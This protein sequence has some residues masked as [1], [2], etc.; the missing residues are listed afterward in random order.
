MKTNYVIAAHHGDVR[1]AG[2][3]QLRLSL[4]ASS[5]EITRNGIAKTESAK[6]GHGFEMGALQRFKRQGR[7]RR[8]IRCRAS[9]VS[10]TVKHFSESSFK[11]CQLND[12]IRPT[13]A[14]V[15]GRGSIRPRLCEITRKGFA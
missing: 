8:A 5:I 10:F 4:V 14:R 6:T 7:Q 1:T 12:E 15:L 9:F 2:L 11:R 13:L 3:R